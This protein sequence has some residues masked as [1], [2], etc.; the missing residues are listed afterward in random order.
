MLGTIYTGQMGSIRQKLPSVQ[1]R[2]DLS[3]YGFP[4]GMGVWRLFGNVESG[5]HNVFGFSVAHIVVLAYAI[6]DHAA[7]DHD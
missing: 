4:V 3:G 2:N 7:F 1:G 5:K 6:I